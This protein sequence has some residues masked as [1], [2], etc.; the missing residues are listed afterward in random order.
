MKILD[1]ITEIINEKVLI[2]LLE[3]V[4]FTDNILLGRPILAIIWLVLVISNI[5]ILASEKEDKE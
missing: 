5:I 4:L 3:F 1:K 2:I